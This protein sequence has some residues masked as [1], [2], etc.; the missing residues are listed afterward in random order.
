MRTAQASLAAVQDQQSARQQIQ[1]AHIEG[2]VVEQQLLDQARLDPGRVAARVLAQ[3]VQELARYR[4]GFFGRLRQILGDRP[5]VSVVG[6]F[7]S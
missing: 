6:G 1:L 7:S 5:G 4:S 2:P 3:K